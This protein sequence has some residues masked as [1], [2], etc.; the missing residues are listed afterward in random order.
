MFTS[1]DVVNDE[2]NA[3][4]VINWTT[5]LIR[6]RM[7]KVKKTSSTR[8]RF[9]QKSQSKW[10]TMME[11]PDGS[12]QENHPLLRVCSGSHP[13]GIRPNNW[14]PGQICPAV[15]ISRNKVGSKIPLV[16][17]RILSFVLPPTLRLASSFVDSFHFVLLPYREGVVSRFTSQDRYV[18]ESQGDRKKKHS[19]RMNATGRWKGSDEISDS[20]NFDAMRCCRERVQRIDSIY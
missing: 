13:N 17:S 8:R 7:T 6:C 19:G 20:T 12:Q 10:R 5:C 1:K 4:D 18:A 3:L 2:R 11:R 15:M 14:S 9:Q 16:C